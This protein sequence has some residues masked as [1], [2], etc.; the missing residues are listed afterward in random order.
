MSKLDFM[1]DY[2]GALFTGGGLH[3]RLV[4]EGKIELV[5]RIAAIRSET[6]VD[7]KD[8]EWVLSFGQNEDEL[9]LKKQ[10]GRL[11]CAAF[12]KNGSGWIGKH[13]ALS[14]EWKEWDAKDG[15][16]MAGFSIKVRPVLGTSDG[17]AVGKQQKPQDAILSDDLNDKIPF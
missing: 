2:G 4:Q 5:L 6:F 11:L 15:K 1:E 13:I 17:M 9:R 3:E 16:P 8:P 14:A 7:T 10:P 12:G